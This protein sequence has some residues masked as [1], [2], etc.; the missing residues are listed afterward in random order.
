MAPTKYIENLP[1][2][3]KAVIGARA[4]IG[5]IVLSSDYT[6][7]HEF[8]QVF[9]Q[10][11]VDLYHARILNTPD[12]TPKSLRAMGSTITETA[13]RLLPDDNL[14][15]LAYGCTSASTVLGPD[16]VNDMLRAAK[17]MAKT[18]NPISAAFAAFQAFGA[19]RIA[20]LTPYRNDVNRYVQ[21]ALECGG[22]DI[23]VFGSFNEE[24]DPI[25]SKIDMNSLRNGIRA[26]LDEAPVDAV[27]VS[28]TS[29]RTMHLVN[30][31]E[32]EFDLPITSSNHAMTWHC[33]RLAGVTE[34][35]EGYGS[36][37]RKQIA[38]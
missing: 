22:V 38:N 31:F 6:L 21:T 5:L 7:E 9:T 33:M 26:L 24:L 25:V 30:R 28:C 12:I 27:F 4:R 8:R 36:L 1:F 16:E 19:K 15:V 23:P 32:K 13:S 10:S 29:I 34:T 20:V 3:T 2:T 14:D 17:P 35:I 18:T 11:G 37:F